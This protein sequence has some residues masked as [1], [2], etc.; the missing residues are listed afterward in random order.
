MLK[1]YEQSEEQQADLHFA[2][3]KAYDD[4]GQYDCAIQHFDA[5]NRLKHRTNGSY[6]P[7]GHAA[8]VDRQIATFT[9]DFFARN[10]ALGSDCQ[11]PIL[12]VGMP[13]SGTTL[14]E[15]ILS[16]HPHVSAG[17]ELG[18]WGELAVSFAMSPAGRID[19]AWAAT[20]AR[21]YQALLSGI[22]LTARRVT[23]KLPHNFLHIP[24]IHSVFPRARVIH[25]RRH[26]IDTCLPIYFENFAR[27]MEFAYDRSDLFAFYRQYQR[28]M[29]HW[30]SV[31]STECFFEIQYEELVANREPWTRKMIAFCGLEWG[32]ACLHSQR[33]PRPVRTASVW[34][35]RQPV[36]LTSVARW[37]R[38]E[39]WLGPL[40]ELLADADP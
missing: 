27:R 3:G 7:A 33:N 2:L 17:G 15:Q 30:R 25:C 26:P 29:A 20:T 8:G 37:R 34:Q 36:Y 32:D 5:G 16:S 38:Y 18:F 14:V 28:L 6:T 40:R 22:S 31:L 24:M 35:A 1:K 19:P 23:D 11:M 9:D 4:L 13:R 12:V 39:P 21:E 10:A